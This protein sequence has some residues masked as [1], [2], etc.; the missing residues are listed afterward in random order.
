[1][2]QLLLKINHQNFE[3]NTDKSIFWR[4]EK[5][6]M[7]SDLHLGKESHFRKSGIAVPEGSGLST[8]TR[9]SNL[10]SYY[11]PNVL[12]FLGDLFHSSWNDSC[13]EYMDII[14]K[15]NVDQLILVSGNHDILAHDV[16]IN[17]RIQVI[18]IFTRHGF[19]F[20]HEPFGSNN[21]LD[22]CFSGHIHPAIQISKGK[23]SSQRF[24]CFAQSTTQM[25]LPA[26]GQFTG[27]VILNPSKNWK[28]HFIVQH[29][30]FSLEL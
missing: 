19:H 17:H 13:A 12:L 22:F 26:F 29:S 23:L 27:N 5:L 20:M 15:F 3:L 14:S 7:M 28:Y 1:M 25:I 6:L 9:L 18:D 10:C 21:D 2:K 16:Y 24:P 30:L 11:Q 4:E 8:I